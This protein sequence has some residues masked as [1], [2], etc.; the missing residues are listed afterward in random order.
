MLIFG[1]GSD[2]KPE[3]AMGGITHSS[4]R[5]SYVKIVDFGTAK[6][7]EQVATGSNDELK[8]CQDT[9]HKIL[10]LTANYASVETLAARDDD[11][12]GYNPF[13]NDVHCLGAMMYVIFSGAMFPAHPTDA[14]IQAALN[15]VPHFKCHQCK[16][17]EASVRSLIEGMTAKESERLT[18]NEV[19][20]HPWMTT[21][22]PDD[23][24]LPEDVFAGL[25]KQIFI[26][27]KIDGKPGDYLV[28][29][30]GTTATHIVKAGDMG[31]IYDLS[32]AVPIDSLTAEQKEIMI[33]WAPALDR[34]MMFYHA[35]QTRDMMV[36]KDGTLKALKRN[37][38]NL[39]TQSAAGTE[40]VEV[41]DENQIPRNQDV[42]NF[43]VSQPF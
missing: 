16:S 24:D 5:E 33:K 4:K 43:V 12:A 39:R 41:E 15:K 21:P 35:K 31:A 18:I 40:M 19:L 3:N 9:D 20:E 32:N 22:C 2:L 6:H 23:E 42:F 38:S 29:E 30:V 11:S 28:Q 14:A 36:I 1:Y 34:G 13:A 10:M 7:F 8:S 25:I 26:A 37:W 17:Y 27:I